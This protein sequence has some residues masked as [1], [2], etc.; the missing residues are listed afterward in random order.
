MN[1]RDTVIVHFINADTNELISFYTTRNFSETVKAFHYMKY[2]SDITIVYKDI[3][4]TV[5][6]VD[7]AIGGD[8]LLTCIKV[9]IN[10][11]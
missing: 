6:D 9:Y 1:E 2:N 5:E 10:V 4:G 3:E 11:F 7:I 8:E